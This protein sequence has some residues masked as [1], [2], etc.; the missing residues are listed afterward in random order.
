MSINPFQPTFPPIS[1]GEEEEEEFD[2][3]E[4]K[5]EEEEVEEEK[6]EEH[7]EE[8]WLE[9]Y[10]SYSSFTEEG[11]EEDDDGDDVKELNTSPAV[12]QQK[13]PYISRDPEKEESHHHSQQFRG[14]EK[15]L[16]KQGGFLNSFKSGVLFPKPLPLVKSKNFD[17]RMINEFPEELITTTLP[18]PLKQKPSFYSEEERYYSEVPNEPLYE[19]FPIRVE[20]KSSSPEKKGA[21]QKL[22][23]KLLL[24][25]KPAVATVAATAAAT[26]VAPAALQVRSKYIND[27]KQEQGGFHFPPLPPTPK[28]KRDV[29]KTLC[30]SLLTFLVISTL[31][32][33]VIIVVI[34]YMSLRFKK[35]ILPFDILNSLKD[36]NNSQSDDDSYDDDSDDDDD[37]DSDDDL[38]ENFDGGDGGVDKNDVSK[39]WNAAAAAAAAATPTTRES[40]G[41]ENNKNIIISRRLTPPETIPLVVFKDAILLRNNKNNPITFYQRGFIHYKDYRYWQFFNDEFFKLNYNEETGEK[42]KGNKINFTHNNYTSKYDMDDDMD[43]DDGNFL[44]QKYNNNNF[45]RIGMSDIFEE[46]RE[47]DDSSSISSSIRNYDENMEGNDIAASLNVREIKYKIKDGTS[48]LCEVQQIVNPRGDGDEDYDSESFVLLRNLNPEGESIIRGETVKGFTLFYKENNQAK[49][50][51]GSY[52]INFA[53]DLGKGFSFKEYPINN[54]R[55]R[56]VND[57]DDDDDDNGDDDSIDRPHRYA[58]FASTLSEFL[59]SSSSGENIQFAIS[60]KGGARFQYEKANKKEYPFATRDNNSNT[61]IIAIDPTM[62]MTLVS[63]ND[64]HHEGFLTPNVKLFEFRPYFERVFDIKMEVEFKPMRANLKILR[65][66][67]LNKKEDKRDNYL[68]YELKRIP[69]VETTINNDDN[70][71]NNNNNNNKKKKKKKKEPENNINMRNFLYRA[72]FTNNPNVSQTIITTEDE[73]PSNNDGEITTTTNVID[74]DNNSNNIDHR[75]NKY[76]PLLDN[77]IPTDEIYG[78]EVSVK[79]PWQSPYLKTIIKSKGMINNLDCRVPIDEGYFV[80]PSVTKE[81]VHVSKSFFLSGEKTNKL[82]CYCWNAGTTQDDDDGD[83]DA[84]NNNNNVVVS[85]ANDRLLRIL[86]EC[87]ISNLRFEFLNCVFYEPVGVAI[88]DNFIVFSCSGS[89]LINS[90]AE[91]PIRVTVA[92]EDPGA[93][94]KLIFQKFS[95][96]S[97]KPLTP[98]TDHD[99]GD[100]DDGVGDDGDSI[101]YYYND[102]DVFHN[103]PTFSEGKSVIFPKWMLVRVKKVSENRYELIESNPVSLKQFMGEKD[104]ESPRY[105]FEFEKKDR[106]AVEKTLLMSEIEMIHYFKA[107]ENQNKEDILKFYSKKRKLQNHKCYIEENVMNLFLLNTKKKN[108]NIAK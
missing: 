27:E 13:P 16:T 36:E 85:A 39:K 43:D 49:K 1:E 25:H 10:D 87:N 7:G 90:S 106:N 108:N 14:E 3:D 103:N 29:G 63:R 51:K 79:F 80:S 26:A 70:N 28:E 73:Q 105:G 59:N 21:F 24:F 44:I 67:N 34:S 82:Y 88:T 91:R 102:S 95:V 101:K 86:K 60:E 22:K 69:L 19:N 9:D 50:Y 62:G 74:N 107:K 33:S 38:D 48:S 68:S 57:D 52:H 40:S 31:I 4:Q 96:F 100:G 6:E 12:V 75:F 78:I 15:P 104:D 37:D 89:S 32:C 81:S 54:K 47:V 92:E 53:T 5:S 30:F 98:V 58:V 11:E 83:G 20:E 8:E 45:A 23:S 76:F 56:G 17:N 64:Y 35:K 84:K 71:N 18:T 93:E 94:I 61:S 46:S 65:I 55:K 97:I 2:D 66:K 41:K 42:R 99:D 72:L 77:T